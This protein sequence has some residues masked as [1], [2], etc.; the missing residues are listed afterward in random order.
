MS[1]RTILNPAISLSN[2]LNANSITVGT[3]NTANLASNIGT[4]SSVDAIACAGDG[5]Y[6]STSISA[7]TLSGNLVFC[8]NLS[9]GSDE[10]DIAAVN[11]YNSVDPTNPIL[12]I[13]TSQ[14]TIDGADVSGGNYKAPL[15]SMTTTQVIINGSIYPTSFVD[16]A[17]S[18][19]LSG[20]VITANGT[21]GWSWA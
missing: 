8:R 4:I 11:S 15:V 12:N 21:G 3:V 16:S 6:G 19:G 20:Q 2:G 1:A 17:G 13:Y 14:T 9:G 7:G 10:L 18:S 5:N